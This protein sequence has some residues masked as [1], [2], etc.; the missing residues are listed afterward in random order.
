MEEMVRQFET[1]LSCSMVTASRF[2]E[3]LVERVQDGTTCSQVVIWSSGAKTPT[4]RR[5]LGTSS[6]Y[7]FG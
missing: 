7:I 5:R 1:D 6:T 3:G 4:H 2:G